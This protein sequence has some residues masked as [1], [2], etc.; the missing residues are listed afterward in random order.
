MYPSNVNQPPLNLTNQLNYDW[1]RSKNDSFY[2]TLKDEVK[3]DCYAFEPKKQT[4]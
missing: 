4:D 3:G 2:L 1:H